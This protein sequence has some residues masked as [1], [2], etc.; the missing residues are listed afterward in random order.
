MAASRTTTSARPVSTGPF[1]RT[2]RPASSFSPPSRP[3]TKP[4]RSER[5]PPT[6]DRFQSVEGF[7]GSQYSDFIIGSNN[8]TASFATS[9]FTG[10]ILTNFDLI[11]G[12]RG[13]VESFQPGATFF[14]GEILLG[15][16][17]SDIIKGGWGDEI[18]DGDA[19]LNVQIGV[20]ANG[21]P[22][23]SGTP[24][25]LYN[26]MA[27]LRARVF[28]GEI[29]VSQ[30]GIVREIRDTLL[31]PAHTPTAQL[32]YD[33]V[34]FA[35]NRADY[36]IEQLVMND[37]GTPADATDDFAS[38]VRVTHRVNGVVGLDGVDVVRNVERL[39]FADTIV[40]L[41]PNFPNKGPQ[42]LLTVSDVTPTE[43]QL[44]MVSADGIIDPDNVTLVNP[45]GKVTGPVTSYWQAQGIDGNFSDVVI[46]DG[47]ALRPATGTTFTPSDPQS[48]LALRVRAVYTDANGIVET[49]FSTPTARVEA[50][51]DPH[52]GSVLINDTTPTQDQALVAVAALV[53]PDQPLPTVVG[54][55]A[56]SITFNYQWQRSLDLGATW[57]DIAGANAAQYVPAAADVY[58][59]VGNANTLLRAKVSYVDGQGFFEQDF[60][61][62]TTQI[63]AHLVRDGL[64]NTLTGTPYAD[65]LE[66]GAGN[67][68]M[69]GGAGADIMVGGT[70]NDLYYVADA[71][72][73]VIER[74]TEGVDQV[75]TVLT[76]YTLGANVEN[77]TFTGSGDFTGTGNAL[78]NAIVGG[79]ANDTLYGLDGGDMINGGAGDDIIDGGLGVDFMNG[80]AGNDTYFV[81]RT[82]DSVTEAANEG[83]DLVYS[84]ASVYT[85]SD[86]D[87]E[88]LTF[89]GTG[90]F[91]GTG[92]DAANRITGGSGNDILVGRGGNDTIDGGAGNDVLDGGLGY[93]ILTGGAGNDTFRYG[94]A[95]AE[96]G[97]GLNIRDVITDFQGAG[98][99]G[100]DV[101]DLSALDANTILPGDQAFELIGN[102]AF[103]APGQ[104]RWSQDVANNRTII[105]GN[106][107]SVLAVDFQIEV[108][109][110]QLFA[111][112]NVM[113]AT[114]SDFVL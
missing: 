9:G 5:T 69:Q 60:S 94:S 65:W 113:N 109:G 110:L 53:D 6:I 111:T 104:L 2:V 12:L 59:A 86:I 48:G 27:D 8:L 96:S 80:G 32:G 34:S 22:T 10:S 105:E 66:G 58:N 81:D 108:M 47:V 88:N 43:N 56:P 38:V 23:H 62:A 99:A 78:G 85:L 19:W 100:G 57:I 39:E 64:A 114:A 89:I 25:S 33:T 70:G 4:R 79:S 16:A 15:G 71:G 61:Q 46:N 49:V 11:H 93:D 24:L 45:T 28:S 44:L 73:E 41:N 84:T 37:N 40:V 20:Y 31:D 74:P 29:N 54:G 26:S 36:V 72:D 101:I 97:N 95:L 55:V 77:L 17:G 35:G 90:P 107:D 51:N 91:T 13:L 83:T 87:V 14:A 42:N 50:V 112:S 106:V 102:A 76:T 92:N 63:G 68:V 1:T 52:T 82:T 21:D 30:L 67:D 98:A 75:Q 18:I 3:R 103:S 7:S